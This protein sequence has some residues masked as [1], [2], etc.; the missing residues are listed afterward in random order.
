MNISH[1]WLRAFVPHA[2]GAERV[3]DLLTAHVATVEGFERLRADL[4]PFV[5]ARVVETEKVPDTKLSFNKVDDGSG[6]LLEVVCGAPN[7]TLGAMYPFARSGTMMPAGFKIEKKKIRGFTSN[8]MLCSARELGLGEDAAGIMELDTDAAPGTPL[9]SVLPLGDVRLVL[10][11]LPNRPD[12]LS[13]LGVARELSAL[14]GVA[15]TSPLDAML[16]SDADGAAAGRGVAGGSIL[17]DAARD[18]VQASSGGATVRLEDAEGCPR[19]LGAVIRGIAV[20]PSPAWLRARVEAAGVRSINNVVDVTNYVLHGLGQPMHAFDLGTL[21]EQTIVVRR[22]RAGE[23]LVTLDGVE[24]TLTPEMTMIADARQ[25]IAVAGVMGGRD[26]EVTGRTTDVLLEVAYFDPRRTRRTRRALGL[27][28]DASYRFERGIDPQGLETAL[29]VAASLM[30]A[31]AGGHVDG[32]MI[33]VGAVPAALPP[34]TLRPSRVASVLGAAVSAGE[35]VRY[36]TS[37]GFGVEDGGEG[38]ARGW[39]EY[40]VRGELVVTPP[41]WR[42]D[43]VHEVDLIEDVAR[44]HGYDRLPE[45]IEAYRPTTVPDHPLYVTGRRVRDALVASGLAEVRPMPFLKGDDALH[46]RVTNPLSADEP[47]LRTSVL[48]SL[49]PLAEYNLNRMQGDVR[50]FEVGSVFGGKDTGTVEEEVRV[51]ILMMGARAPRHF[52]DGATQAA[53]DAW[54]AKALAE[55]AT[56]SIYPAASVELSAGEE[57]LLWRVAVD[58]RSVGEVTRLTL[59]APVWAS[60]AFGIE[61]VLGPMPLAAV[62]APG[63]SAHAGERLAAVPPL[64]SVQYIP[65]PTTPAAL[66]DLAL[67][68]PDDTPAG[69]VERVLRTSGGDLL[70]RLELFDEFRGPGVPDGVRSLAWRLTFR[71]PDRTLRDKE[72]EGRRTQLLKS[73][74]NQLGVKPRTA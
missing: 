3:R 53:I 11:V 70:E 73:L 33:A 72:I 42:R 22:A 59:D 34:V 6:T 39:A 69:D 23:K 67:L 36:L 8:G 66:F 18:A 29:Q 62:A 74:E 25:S 51:G 5:V 35:I 40:G 32:G 43:V 56:R 30:V 15:M 2:L 14:V 13:H 60:P 49:K 16:P 24:R 57:P 38:G 17:G 54:D 71:H 58:G 61:L 47:H 12:L 50:I 28:T 10:D 52:T 65:M 27:S 4:A 7:V 64:P 68:V 21:A 9:L 37:I 20:G 63:M 45:T 19:Y 26:S 41:S 46:W 55:R 44:L 31:V 1:D 48:Q